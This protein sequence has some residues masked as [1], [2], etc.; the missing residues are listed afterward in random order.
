LGNKW[1]SISKTVQG[2]HIVAI[3][4]LIANRMW[5][6]R[7]TFSDLESHFCCLT[8]LCSSATVVYNHDCALAE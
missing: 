4:R 1:Y 7:V 3:E 2:R 5:R 8:P 6:L